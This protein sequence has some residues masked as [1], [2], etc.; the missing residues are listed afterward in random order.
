MTRDNYNIKI[1]FSGF[2]QPS[3]SFE[4]VP[5]WDTGDFG[6]G[7][8]VFDT[9]AQAKDAAIRYLDE[10]H[11]DQVNNRKDPIKPKSLIRNTRLEDIWYFFWETYEEDQKILDYLTEKMSPDEFDTMLKDIKEPPDK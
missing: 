5:S 11:Y 8:W 7:E 4:I 3:F 6:T 1:V 2:G 9:L 10:Q